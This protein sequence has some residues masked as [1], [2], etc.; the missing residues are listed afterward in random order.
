MMNVNVHDAQIDLSSLLQRVLLGEEIIITQGGAPIAI[1][2]PIKPKPMPRIPGNDA[3]TVIIHPDF[4]APLPE[5][6]A[7]LTA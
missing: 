4:D 3:H 6:E 5:F 7:E 2:A 1:L